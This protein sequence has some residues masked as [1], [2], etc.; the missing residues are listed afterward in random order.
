MARFSMGIENIP[1]E[2]PKSGR[3]TAISAIAGVCKQ[4]ASLRIGT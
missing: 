2:N 1:S 3:I 4:R